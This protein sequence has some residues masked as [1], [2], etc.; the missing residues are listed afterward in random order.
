[1]TDSYLSLFENCRLCPRRCGVNRLAGQK[2]ICGVS[3]QLHVARASL[4][5]WEEPTIS[6]NTGSGTIF[7]SG[8]SLHCVYCQNREISSGEKGK[9]ITSHR[10]LEIMFELVEKGASTINLVT[11]TQYVPYLIEVLPQARERGLKVPVVYNTSGYECVETLRL[12]KGLVGV[13]LTDYKYA[14]ASCARRY[15]SCDTYVSYAQ[16]ALDEMV[17]Q[18]GSPQYENNSQAGKILT[19]GVV[20]RHLLLPGRLEEA[21]QVVAYIH[22][23]YGNKVILSLMNQYTP[24]GDSAAYPELARK[25]LPEEY[26]AL[27]DY[28]DA[29]GVED[30]YWQEGGA[31]EESFIPSFDNRGV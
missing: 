12:L 4:H 25:V 30:Y 11:P 17:L 7:F 18:V 27:L 8:C 22:S 15:S 3:A 16:A 1:M 28:A 31:A 2:G 9:S 23:R 21:K 24:C 13:Y 29:L 26:E 20:V 19:S 14:D 6:G 10:L 5:A